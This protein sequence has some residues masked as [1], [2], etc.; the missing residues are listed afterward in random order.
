MDAHSGSLILM[1]TS[2][3]AQ[4]SDMDISIF[5]SLA[6]LLFLILFNA[7]YAASE[8]AV[9]TLNDNKVRRMAE[10]GDKNSKKIIKFMD[11]PTRFL[12][13]IQV[14]ITFA[15]FFASAFAADRFAGPLTKAI[16]PDGNMPWLITVSVIFITIMLSYFSLVFG[17]LVPKRVAMRSP[18]KVIKYTIG[19]LTVTAAGLRPFVFFLTFSTNLILRIIGI[20]P[21]EHE[22]TVTEEEIRMM[23]DVGRE[24]GTIHENE[25]EM[26]E[27]IFE[28]NDT[29]VSEIMTHRTNIVSLDSEAD[30]Q[31]VLEIAVNEQFTRIPVYK[32]SIDNII[33][34][35][36]IKDLLSI[37]VKGLEQPFSLEKIIREP[38]F[39]P[40]TKTIDETFHEMQKAHVQIAI[41][42][43]EYGGTAG[44]I[45]MEDLLE[46]IVGNMQDE[47][48]EES[49]EIVRQDDNTLI[50]DGMTGLDEIVDELGIKIPVDHDYDTIAGMVI[51]LLGR[52]PDE[53]EHP[54]V[55]FE[56][57]NFT[58]LAMEDKRISKIRITMVPAND[59]TQS[60]NGKENNRRSEQDIE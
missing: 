3:A 4:V 22:K 19:L 38:F 55:I 32:D 28:F 25:K 7:A 46:E 13:T 11:H 15:G 39:V 42:I 18:Y 20:N 36:L 37:A 29:Q 44:I 12:S 1:Q 2:K 27:N 35:L 57:V 10:E 26:I 53:D 60:T 40:D 59:S 9:I 34:I 23:V 5:Y 49:E 54:E 16:D 30:F 31:E 43:D 45:T 17:E 48:D 52:I 41:V 33:G 50:V 8:M 51:D 56:N 47:Y 21:E 24:T 58:V 6:I 14:G